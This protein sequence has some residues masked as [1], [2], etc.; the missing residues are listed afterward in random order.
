MKRINDG[1]EHQDLQATI[2]QSPQA[3]MIMALEHNADP[4]VLGRLMDLQ[5]RYDKNQAHKAY[6]AAMAEFKREA[7]S[8]LA[9]D[10]TV[11]FTSAKGRTHYKHAT[12]G[13]IVAA[14]T[15]ALSANGLSIS[16]ETVQ[17]ADAVRVTCHVTHAMGHRESVSLNGPP[18][19]S[20]NKNRIQM[21]GSA[22]TYLQRYTMLAALGLATADQDDADHAPAA[23]K[24]VSAPKP[25]DASNAA[26]GEVSGVIE[27]VKVKD[28]GTAEKP[29]TK[30]GVY[31]GGTAYGTFDKTTGEAARAAIGRGCKATYKDDGKYRTLV[32]L[33]I[34]PADADLDNLM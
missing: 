31:I 34:A 1:T 26:A 23:R 9:K 10:A 32:T 33:E 25:V 11:D 8:V 14:I 2:D 28:G 27:D 21:I 16:W 22:V 6:V 13:G 5:E 30:Y 7:P 12:L 17:T 29:W 18:D 20:G 3:M 15:P 19:D 24:P 4:A